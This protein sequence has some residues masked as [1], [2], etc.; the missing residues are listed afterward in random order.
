MFD[1]LSDSNLQVIYLCLLTICVFLYS[2]LDGYDLGIGILSLIMKGEH[3][4]DAIHAIGPFWDA[5]ETWL[6]LGIMII[7][8]VFPQAGQLMLG[9]LYIPIALML[10]ALLLRA[11]AYEFQ[12]KSLPEHKVFWVWAFGIGSLVASLL[13]G[14]MVGRYMSGFSDSILGYIL[15]IACMISV[16]F[17]YVL[18]GLG[19]MIANRVNLELSLVKKIIIRCTD[20]IL[21]S[22]VMVGIFAP[23]SNHIIWQNW[24][25][26]SLLPIFILPI[27][28]TITLFIIRI[29]PDY[30]IKKSRWSIIISGFA[31]LGCSL[32][33]IPFSIWPN[34]IDNIPISQ[35]ETARS[36]LEIVLVGAIVLLPS[37]LIYTLFG[38]HHLMVKHTNQIGK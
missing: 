3:R 34:I 7:S 26:I 37:I 13:Q 27:L 6:V 2:L 1:T 17:F 12:A 29:A 11:V 10:V 22:F 9:R 18:C 20:I 32:V 38:Y 21:I 4:E 23:L 14:W 24:T 5:N 25:K 15:S 31:I 30:L 8:F 33:A 28:G 16:P 19:W 36:S 35:L